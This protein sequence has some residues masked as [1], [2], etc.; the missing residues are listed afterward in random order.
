LQ[1]TLHIYPSTLQEHSMSLNSVPCAYFRVSLRDCAIHSSGW[2]DFAGF[3]LVGFGFFVRSV[4]IMRAFV[5][6]TTARLRCVRVFVKLY[7]LTYAPISRF[8]HL[9]IMCHHERGSKDIFCTHT[10]AFACWKYE[11]LIPWTAGVIFHLGVS[12]SGLRDEHA[13]MRVVHGDAMVARERRCE[14]ILHAKKK[15]ELTMNIY[16]TSNRFFLFFTYPHA[17]IRAQQ[18]DH[19]VFQDV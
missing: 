7:S 2:V 9:A 4:K 16:A 8:P 18:P 12:E 5:N 13:D 6:E 15:N 11:F 3:C 17:C 10:E 19:F 1:S 14:F